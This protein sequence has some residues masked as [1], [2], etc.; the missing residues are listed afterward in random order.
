M[1]KRDR[2]HAVVRLQI[3]GQTVTSLKHHAGRPD[4][5]IKR[6]DLSRHEGLHFIMTMK[7]TIRQGSLWV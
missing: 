1:Q 6:D 4:L 2:A 7:G 3:K 5:D